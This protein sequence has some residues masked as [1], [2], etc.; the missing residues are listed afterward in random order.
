ME[1]YISPEGEE[2]IVEEQAT[3]RILNEG[4]P[5][6]IVDIKERRLTIKEDDLFIY[7]DARGNLSS[8]NTA[9][10]GFYTDD[11]RFLSC[12]ELSVNGREPIL[13]STSAQRD[14]MAHI[15]LTNAD[16]SEGEQLKVAQETI[17][18]RRL[19]VL[20][21]GL[22]ERIRIKNYNHVPVDLYLEFGFFA[23]FADMF[24]VRGMRRKQRGRLFQPKLTGDHLVLAYLG[25]DDI[26]RQTRIDLPRE[27]DS[28][29]LELNKIVLGYKVP[30]AANGR[31][32]L[33]FTIQPVT[34]KRKV[35]VPTFN[36][37]ISDVR[38]SYQK[39]ERSCTTIHTDNELF[40]S[41]T[42][43]GRDDMRSLMTGSP[44]G[45]VIS[46]GIPWYVAPF[47][48]DSLLAAL[49]IMPLNTEPARTTL[50]ILA[51]YQGTEENLW[52][53]EEPGKIMHELRLGELAS[54]GEIPH[55]PYYGSI[56]STPL[57]LLVLSEYYKWTGDL[58]FVRRHRPNIV[59]ALEWID[60]YGDADGDGFIEY[61]RKSRRGLINQG[62]KDSHNSIA[63]DNGE[64]AR[65][66]IALVE[67]QAYVYYAKKRMAL[68][69][70][71]LGEPETAA[72]L[73]AEAQTLKKRFNEVFWS[74]KNSFYAMA[75]DGDKR[76]VETIA[77]N[78]GQCLWSGI[79]DPEKADAVAAKL[80]DPAMFS[81]WGI[82]TVSKNASIYNPMSYHNGSIWP[83]D[84][85][86]IIRGLKRY[87]K[88]REV[89]HVS[90]GLFDAAI[91]HSY[92]RLPELFCGFTRR[93]RSD[94]VEYPVACSPQAWAA[95]TVFM[96]LQ[97][98][99][100]LTPDAPNNTL[101]INNPTLP[102][103]LN[104]VSLSNLRIGSGRLTIAFT[105]RDGVTSFTVPRKEGKIRIVMEE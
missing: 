10:L 75:L 51:H 67:V 57:W 44:F 76:K 92:F 55:T 16:I 53:D 66:P 7:C 23:D 84:N 61:E 21:G 64:N 40:N 99:L 33:N 19:R 35:E 98:I 2:F 20:A 100:G 11:T 29:R 1:K 14:Y 97:S 4:I 105:R 85:A 18:I 87:G 52:R 22:L 32:V 69:F 95:G 26:F 15:E 77:S 45:Q 3:N 65:A 42:E 31:A 47:G 86:I 17:N 71:D 70:S 48:R 96:L 24:E 103:W 43:R 28:H 6:I 93:G 63:H 9:G 27:P 5:F 13:L 12:W 62:W 80:L 88:L 94:P 8:D 104:E 46:A 74:E 60:K 50:E 79:M 59:A 39:W 89:E 78:A 72:R 102:R 73:S 36:K 83:H 54:L 56:D 91:H 81:G 58:D 41:V 38:R 37:A 25:Q 49:Q 30:L 82:R 90:S 101:W 34:G 68:V